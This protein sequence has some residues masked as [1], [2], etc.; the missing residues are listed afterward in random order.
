ML[1]GDETYDAMAA[2][3]MVR[4]LVTENLDM[5]SGARSGYGGQR[6]SPGP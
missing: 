6:I 1:D 4:K 2:P 3:A 5:V